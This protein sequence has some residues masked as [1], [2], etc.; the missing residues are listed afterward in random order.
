[1]LLMTMWH[2]LEKEKLTP[3]QAALDATVHCWY[4]GH[5][6]GHIAVGR[7][8]KFLPADGG[9]EW[10]RPYP[11]NRNPKLQSIFKESRARMSAAPIEAQVAF[12]GALGWA[13]GFEDGVACA[14]DCRPKSPLPEY[15]EV[16]R[17]GRLKLSLASPVRPPRLPSRGSAKRV[18]AKSDRP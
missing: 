9:D 2:A 6:A 13:A 4:E 16:M 5:I 8:V 18:R 10:E 12:G 17:E 15:A 14:G 11:A 3:E 1:M 7:P